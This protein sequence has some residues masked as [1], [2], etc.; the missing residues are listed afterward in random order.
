MDPLDG[1]ELVSYNLL[2]VAATTEHMQSK[3]GSVEQK[4]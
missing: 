4:A 2:V 1:L 3:E